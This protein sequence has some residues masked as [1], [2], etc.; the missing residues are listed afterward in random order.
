MMGVLRE[1]RRERRELSAKSKFRRGK[2]KM[3]SCS[4]Q[5]EESVISLFFL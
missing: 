4:N 5:Q 2:Y 3:P 1:E